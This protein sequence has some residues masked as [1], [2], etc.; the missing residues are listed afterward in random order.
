MQNYVCGICGKEYDNFVPYMECVSKCG[1]ILLQEQKEAERQKRMEEVNAYINR[2]KEAEKYLK[3]IKE[4][5]EKKY[6]REYSL[7]FDLNA[8]S[9][10]TCK[11]RDCEKITVKSGLDKDKNA[12]EKD[13]SSRSIAISVINDGKGE[14]KVDARVNGQK[15]DDDTLSKLFKDPGTR[16]ISKLLEIM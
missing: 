7:N 9:C 6:P 12:N 5:F 13:L 4:E 11:S 1:E 8:V 3:E 14:P 16:Y 2:I 15:V 10:D